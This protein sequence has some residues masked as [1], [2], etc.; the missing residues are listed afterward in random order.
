MAV[1]SELLKG[2]LSLLILSLLGR[3]PMYGYEIARTVREESEG[4]LDWKEGSL[5]PSLH[6][7]ARAGLVRDEWQETPGARRRKYY[8]LTS[9]GRRA[10]AEK[11][12]SWATLREA[13]DRVLAGQTDADGR[14]EER[15][16]REEVESRG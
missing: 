10:L 3:R 6:K 7:L 4:A 15:E 2:T 16:S 13:V 12:Q 1:D 5:Y 14:S 9:D 11:A 8:H